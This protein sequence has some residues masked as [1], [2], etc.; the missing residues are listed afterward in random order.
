MTELFRATQARD[1]N[2]RYKALAIL[3]IGL[4]VILA[5]RVF[6]L[7]MNKTD[8]F[9][10]EAQYWS[11]SRDLAFG[12]FSKP[13]VLAWIVRGVTELCGSSDT[14]CVRLASPLVH[15]AT[16]LVVAG[17]GWILYNAWVGT[18]SGLTYATLPG[19]SLSSSLISTDVPLLLFWALALLAFVKLLETKSW[20]WTIAMGTTL[21]LGLLSKYAMVYFLLCA[22]LVFWF[23]PQTR[24]LVRSV[25]GWTVLLIAACFLAPNIYWNLQN[26]AVTF[27]HTA[28]NANWGGEMFHIGKAVEFFGRPIWRFR[29]G[30]V[31]R[32]LHHPVAGLQR[33]SAA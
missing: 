22:G 1:K 9:F 31:L 14:F 18:W 7:S 11:W 33:G 15:S 13:P 10:D 2:A 17:I 6:A 21:G 23:I 32:P 4:M 25:K 19:V 16:A 28:A 12:Y 29:P 26:G 3:L 8:L 20:G 5:I 27:S 24:W 30:S